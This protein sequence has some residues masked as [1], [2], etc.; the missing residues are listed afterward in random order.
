[1]PHSKQAKKRVKTSEEKRVHNRSIKSTLRT[2]IKKFQTAVESGDAAVAGAVY[3]D[4]QKKLDKSAA[5]KVIRKGTASRVKSR[6]AARLAAVKTPKA[7]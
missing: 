5:K 4:V 1:M 3:Q 6:L 7:G 2:S